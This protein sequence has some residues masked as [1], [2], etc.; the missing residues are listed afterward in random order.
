MAMLVRVFIDHK[1]LK[2]FMMTKKL[3][4]R[5]AKW[6]EFL[7]EFNFVITYQS[8]KKNDKTNAFIK[9]LNKYLANEKDN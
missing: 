3:I 9:K 1:G 2:Y 5:Q 6:A 8:G 7:S 4:L